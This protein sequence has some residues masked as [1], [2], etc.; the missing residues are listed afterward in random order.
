MLFVLFF[1]LAT[2]NYIYHL[3]GKRNSVVWISAG[4]GFAIA[5]G[6]A[7]ALG[8]SQNISFKLFVLLCVCIVSFFPGYVLY[9][10]LST[11][12]PTDPP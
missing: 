4:I 11:Q 1:L 2:G 5:L 3:E 12:G 7:A 8:Y 6:L 10:S 9:D